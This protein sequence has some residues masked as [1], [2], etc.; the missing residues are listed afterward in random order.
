[1]AQI[2]VSARI[3]A[4]LHDRLYSHLFP[5]D[6]DEHGAILLCGVQQSS[7]RLRLLVREVILA[8]EGHDFILSQRGYKELTAQF[9]AKWARYCANHGLAYIAV[10]NHFEGDSVSFSRN[11]LDSHERGYPALLQLT[12][13]GPVGAFVF[14]TRAVA[15]DIWTEE[16]RFTLDSLTVIG[17]RIQVLRPRP[18]R[19]KDGSISSN[20]AF[21][22]HRRLFGSE[23]QTILSSLKGVIVG[24]GGGGSLANEWLA[25]LGIG[26]IVAIDPK[27]IK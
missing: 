12:K 24:L 6:G 23:G 27:R 20:E 16:G 22:R 3:A 25:R 4:H 2:E 19:S 8:E 13:G 7:K 10:H 1:M 14:A 9:V 18:V 5:G 15:G 26:H 21:D 11:D 17:P